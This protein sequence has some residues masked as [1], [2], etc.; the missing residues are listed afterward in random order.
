MN[1]NVD[2]CPVRWEALRA[3]GDDRWC[4]HCHKTVHNLSAMTE[5]G[6]A[7]FVRKNPEACVSYRRRPDG[8]VATRA[9]RAAGVV[10]VAA[11][12]MSTSAHATDIWLET[13]L[14]GTPEVS[15]PVPANDDDESQTLDFGGLRDGPAW[16]F[17][18]HPKRRPHGPTGSAWLTV[19]RGLRTV[20]KKVVLR[21]FSGDRLLLREARPFP[22]EQKLR[23][24]D[25]P[26]G[27]RCEVTLKGGS[28]LAK[29]SITTPQKPE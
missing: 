16:N 3:R 20:W 25:L 6:A 14:K 21:C 11:T 22:T 17:D 28:P 13:G 10:A 5:G 23:F 29:V 24:R 18:C 26:N 19:D 12:L 7:R 1:V 27:Q 2:P 9:G 8:S 15:V 4:D